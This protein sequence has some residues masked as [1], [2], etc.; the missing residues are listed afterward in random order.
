MNT[1]TVTIPP[2]LL[3]KLQKL[4]PIQQKQIEDYVDFLIQ[5]N[6]KIS[7]ESL[8]REEKRV[9]GLNKGMMTMTDDF[10][11]SVSFDDLYA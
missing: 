1:P 3:D 10:N 7:E 8:P 4:Y 9:L 5:K 6:E 11:E 2:V